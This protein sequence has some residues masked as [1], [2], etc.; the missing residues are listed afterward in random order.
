MLEY[1]QKIER[2]IGK[3]GFSRENHFPAA[4]IGKVY[5]FLFR[6]SHLAQTIH[7]NIFIIY[8]DNTAAKKL[9]IGNA[10]QEFL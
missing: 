10:P 5:D 1:L 6:E 8:G 7:D 4:V 2:G 3:S 9:Y